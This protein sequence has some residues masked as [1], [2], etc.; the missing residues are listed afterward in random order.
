[1]E[2]VR[3]EFKFNFHAKEENTFKRKHWIYNEIITVY[4]H[5]MAILVCERKHFFFK[6]SFFLLDPEEFSSIRERKLF[7][8]Q[9]FFFNKELFKQNITPIFKK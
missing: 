5:N 7:F 9:Q 8:K 1:M 6:I 3:R 2:I 4:P